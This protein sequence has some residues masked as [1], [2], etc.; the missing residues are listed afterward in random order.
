MIKK[1]GPEAKTHSLF[2]RLKESL[3]DVRT[4]G[5]K[6]KATREGPAGD[7]GMEST[8]TTPNKGKNV[9]MKTPTK[10]EKEDEVYES[11]DEIQIFGGGRRR[12]RQSSPVSAAAV[13][14]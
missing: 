2:L 8:G 7:S 10:K 5:Q 11:G 14:S 6:K 9:P 3:T 4:R 13:P 12:R 1:D